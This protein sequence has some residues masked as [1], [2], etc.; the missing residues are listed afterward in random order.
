MVVGVV[1]D[2]DF[3]THYSRATSDCRR[4]RWRNGDSWEVEM[5]RF[6]ENDNRTFKDIEELYIARLECLQRVVREQQQEIESLNR[7]IDDL[8]K[9]YV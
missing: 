3:R 5:T 6:T 2:L 1:A 7:M 9:E 4:Y 8:A